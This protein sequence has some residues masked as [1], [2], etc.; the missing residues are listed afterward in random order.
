MTVPNRVIERLK[1]HTVVDENG[2]WIWQ[3][4]VIN[5]YGQVGWDEGG[6][7]FR[8]LTHRVMYE[9]ANGAIPDGLTIDHTCHDPRS[10]KPDKASDC[11]HRRCC[12]PAHLRLATRGENVLR[13]GG[14]APENLSKAQCPAGHPYDNANTY[15]APNGWRQCRVCRSGH[16]AAL[17][18]R[19]AS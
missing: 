3:R 10:C 11:P 5:G 16:I 2:C 18:A 8:V 7:H 4:S 13:G 17:R 1:A 6:Q 19:R 15:V 9:T 12:N 14:F